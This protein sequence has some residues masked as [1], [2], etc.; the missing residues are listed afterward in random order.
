MATTKM[1]FLI[2]K[3]TD[4]ST[5]TM[6]NLAATANLVVAAVI[7]TLSDYQA[8]TNTWYTHHNTSTMS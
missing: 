2:S 6:R 5:V 3:A 1:I 7:T 4:L 8:A